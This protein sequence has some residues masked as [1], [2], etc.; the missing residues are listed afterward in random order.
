MIP[1][2]LEVGAEIGA[3]LGGFALHLANQ[4]PLLVGG[5]PGPF[6]IVTETTNA[7]EPFG[8]LGAFVDDFLVIHERS[9]APPSRIVTIA[10]RRCR[11]GNAE[12]V[13]HAEHA[14][15]GTRRIRG[16]LYSKYEDEQ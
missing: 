14:E 10:L 16:N 4:L 12:H 15:R 5:A 7:L 2:R 3:K 13:E 1:G 9:I 11:A 8:Q 6:K